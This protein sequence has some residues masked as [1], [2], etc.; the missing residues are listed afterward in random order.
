MDSYLFLL[1]SGRQTLG[2][3]LLR[4]LKKAVNKIFTIFLLTITKRLLVRSCFTNPTH[5][6]TQKEEALLITNSLKF[7]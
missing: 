7:T 5:K 4:F 1:F 3:N 2:T 6:Q